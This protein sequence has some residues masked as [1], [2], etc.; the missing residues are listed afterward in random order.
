MSRLDSIRLI[1]IYD[2]NNIIMYYFYM[3]SIQEMI[4]PN[5]QRLSQHKKWRRETILATTVEI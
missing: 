4:P 5:Q 3:H 1:R 2:H